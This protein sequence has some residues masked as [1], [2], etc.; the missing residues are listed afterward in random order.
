MQGGER[1][2]E[3]ERQREKDF[4]SLGL[5]IILLFPSWLHP[6]YHP[7]L[8]LILGTFSVSHSQLFFFTEKR[9]DSRGYFFQYL[10][11]TTLMT[12]KY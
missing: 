1:E 7:G 5:F 8:I 3:T 9:F 10:Y 11:S 6:G 12:I 2:R 4:F